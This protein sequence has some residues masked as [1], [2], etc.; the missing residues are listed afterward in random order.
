MRGRSDTTKIAFKTIDLTRKKMKKLYHFI[1]NLITRLCFRR[2]G[3]LL[4][5][6]LN[7]L[8]STAAVCQLLALS[9]LVATAR[10]PP[11]L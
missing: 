8:T 6:R 2:Q 4:E 10:M 1:S 11:G 5:M 7:T 3:R 9:Q